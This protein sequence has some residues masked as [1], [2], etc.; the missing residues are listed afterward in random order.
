MNLKEKKTKNKSSEININLHNILKIKTNT[1]LFPIHYK[2]KE[3][4]ESDLEV[5][6]EEFN[7]KKASKGN[8][9]S[10]SLFF[11]K[12]KNGIYLEHKLKNILMSRW[13]IT[14]SKKVKLYFDLKRN[15][16]SSL[17]SK[18][19]K[20]TWS[21][22][23]LR[24]LLMEMALLKKECTLL[25]CGAFEKNGNAYITPTWSNV[26]KSTTMYLLQ[27]KGYNIIADDLVILSK[28]GKIYPIFK[29]GYAYLDGRKR[30]IRLDTTL[31][32]L[33]A[34][35]MGIDPKKALKTAA[36]M[37]T[38]E[39]WIL[40]HDDLEDDS[41]ER[42]GKPA[43]HKI[44][45]PELAINAGDS[46]HI[47]MWKILMDNE[48]I[49][50]PQKTFEVME[51]F[52]KMLLRATIGQTI[53]IKWTEENKMDFTDDD[54]L[55]IVDGKTVYYTIAGPMR[56]GAIVAGATKDQ[57]DQIFTV[58]TPLGRC[59]QIKDDLLN[60][61]GDRKKYGKEIG[62]DIL[63]GKRTLMLGHLLRNANQEDRKRVEEI[64][65]RPRE[66]KTQEEA[67][68]VIDLMKKYGSIEYGKKIAEKFANEALDKFEKLDFLKENEAKEQL[69]KGIDFMLNRDK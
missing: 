36:A 7:F 16:I 1:N 57:L 59:F 20:K 19:T 4:I 51:E 48:K 62:G 42:R 43:L 31:V 50:G 18:L 5:F 67:F 45:Y 41:E 68:E 32:L 13:L 65:N 40:I 60:L 23:G 69:R 49:L 66:K 17:V 14:N 28:D 2:T 6:D 25:H 22:D 58:G 30:K 64:L 3:N 37:Q 29:E 53:E 52:Y 27:K 8:E 39:D 47:I 61:V 56:L 35:A 12:A 11:W 24:Y 26:G 44:Y 63:E 15:V 46:L 21:A 33:M 55:F 54:Y 38:S 10:F 9:L 34:E